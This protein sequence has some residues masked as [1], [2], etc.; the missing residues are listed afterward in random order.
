MSATTSPGSRDY[1]ATKTSN[2]R[3][4]MREFRAGALELQSMPRKVLVELTQGCN[5]R[6]PMCRSRSIS[7]S[8]R[9]LDRT[10]FYEIAELLFSAAEIVDIRGWG[11]S[12]LAPDVN[13][14]IQAVDSYQ[15]RCRIVTNLSVDRP[16]TLDLLVD[17]GAQIDVSL[18]AVTQEVVDV[19]RPG[20]RMELI[21]ANLR[22]IAGRLRDTGASKDSLRIITTVQAGTLHELT[23]LVRYVSTVG[24]QQ[25]IFNEVSLAPGDPNAVVGL[26]REVGESVRKAAAVAEELGVELYA[27]SQLGDCGGTKNDVQFCSHP[28]AYATVGYDNSRLLR[29]PHRPDDAVLLHG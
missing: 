24:V 16:E 1:L 17:T 12:L 29:P 13:G 28:W 27:G 23:E 18:D 20:A 8:E 10:L 6:C 5:L 15:A 2:A 25:V 9:E 22:R 3:L 19:H 26:E 4:S 11:E 14:I 21:T 7:Y